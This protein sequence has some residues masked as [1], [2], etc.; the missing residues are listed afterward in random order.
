MEMA[1]KKLNR[2]KSPGTDQIWAEIIKRGGWTNR[3]EIYKL[4]NSIWNMDELSGDMK[5]SIIVPYLKE[6]W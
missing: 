5:D 2:Y 4:I 1:M 3:S 6:G